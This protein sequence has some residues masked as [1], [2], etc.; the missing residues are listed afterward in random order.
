MA[1]ERKIV[2]IGDA[3]SRP[4]I[5]SRSHDLHASDIRRAV[6]EIAS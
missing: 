5:T 6:G 4:S 1:L 3:C 2:L